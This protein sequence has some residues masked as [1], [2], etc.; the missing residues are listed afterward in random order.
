[1]HKM[2]TAWMR[3]CKNTDGLRVTSRQYEIARAS[4]ANYLSKYV[5]GENHPSYGKYWSEEQKIKSSIRMKGNTNALGHNVSEEAKRKISNTLKQKYMSGYLT[6]YLSSEE[7]RTKTSARMKG[8]T[9]TIGFLWWNNGIEEKF[10]KDCP[11]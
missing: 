5:K 10:Q 3:M 4:Y 9:Y 2:V 1:M 8:N 7:A 11:R 6:S